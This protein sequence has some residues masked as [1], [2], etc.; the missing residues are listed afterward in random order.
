M[1]E[2]IL[3]LFY[4]LKSDP[5]LSDSLQI[6]QVFLDG[7]QVCAWHRKV[8]EIQFDNISRLMG[9]MEGPARRV[10]LSIALYRS[11][12]E[13]NLVEKC[14]QGVAKE[15]FRDSVHRLVQANNPEA[16]FVN[17]CLNGSAEFVRTELRKTSAMIYKI[18]YEDPAQKRWSSMEICARVLV[19]ASKCKDDSCDVEACSK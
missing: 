3:R 9:S 10:E 7:A 2:I 6:V 15:T 8:I 14:L 16:E 1:V 18:V 17:S 13:K 5:S 12:A 4:G 19:H 11:H